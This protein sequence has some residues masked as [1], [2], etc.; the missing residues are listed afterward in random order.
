M[1]RI[2]K[3][4]AGL[5]FVGAPGIALA[6]ENTAATTSQPSVSERGVEEIV[7]TAQKRSENLQRVPIAITAATEKALDAQHI[8]STESLAAVLPGLKV[9]NSA[10]S[11]LIYLRGIGPVSYTHLTLPTNREV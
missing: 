8:T 7:V 4:C 9:G 1:T 3:I 10:G 5:A 11:G 6:Q 2:V